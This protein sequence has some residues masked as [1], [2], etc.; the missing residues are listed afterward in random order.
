MLDFSFFLELPVE[1]LFGEPFLLGFLILPRLL[2]T[3]NLC[4]PVIPLPPG[5]RGLHRRP[6]AGCGFQQIQ[7]GTNNTS[8]H[9]G[10]IWLAAGASQGK[11]IEHKARYAAMFYD[12]T[13]ISD[14]DRGDTIR[15]QVS[16]NQTHGLVADGSDGC[17]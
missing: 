15:F 6:G 4:L 7:R 16:S 2:L 1:F 9:F 10:L 3:E 13:G 8:L 12:I 17:Q 11:I 14:Y 5:E